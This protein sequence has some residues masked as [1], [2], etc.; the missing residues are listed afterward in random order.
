MLANSRA[1]TPGNLQS[2][3]SRNRY[4]SGRPSVYRTTL[5]NFAT[6]S[7]M[8]RKEASRVNSLPEDGHHS[9][10]DPLAPQETP[11]QW[12]LAKHHTAEKG[13]KRREK[14]LRVPYLGLEVTPELVAIS[15][16]E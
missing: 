11:E 12:L 3:I 2:C 13:S 10:T 16:G 9:P 15:M 5:S 7:A 8:R 6:V 4:A 1:S 14:K